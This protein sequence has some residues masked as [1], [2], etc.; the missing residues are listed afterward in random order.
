L[1]TPY[2]LKLKQ[3]NSHNIIF[4][5]N[6]YDEYLTPKRVPQLPDLNN[7]FLTFIKV[8]VRVEFKMIKRPDER[9][10]HDGM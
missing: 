1:I 5:T 4:V 10:T 8:F 3:T 9:D 2:Y 7:F 6:N